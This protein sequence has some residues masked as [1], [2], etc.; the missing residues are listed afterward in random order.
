MPKITKEEAK[1]ILE[2]VKR[3]KVEGKPNIEGVTRTKKL[4]PKHVKE[5]KVKQPGPAS[6]SIG[7]HG[8]RFI[9]EP[10]GHKRYVKEGQLSGTKRIKKAFDEYF[11]QDIITNFIKSFKK[12]K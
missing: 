1:K 2:R 9:Q 8:G 7:A 11:K 5:Q 12:E 6:V 4:K 10:S 3:K